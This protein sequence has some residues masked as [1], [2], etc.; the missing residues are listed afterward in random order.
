MSFE[1]IGIQYDGS[2]KVSTMQT[3]KA[4]NSVTGELNKTFM[5]VPY[6]IA[7]QL[8]ILARLNEDALQIVEQI[9]PYFQPSFNLTID[10]LDVLGE[11]KDVPI[12]LESISFEDN[13]TEDYLTRREIVY[14]LN[15]TQ[16][17]TCMVLYLLLM[18]VSLRRFRLIHD[19][20]R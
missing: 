11:K 4:V 3:F 9:L 8:N 10:M 1:M 6:N 7:I 15:F 13:Y 16:R 18:R 20:Y 17:P 2:R 14:T 12:V 5:P 19:Q